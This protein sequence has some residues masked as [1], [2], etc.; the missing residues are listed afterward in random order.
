MERERGEG[1]RE[2]TED[3]VR[4]RGSQRGIRE[5]GVSERDRQTEKQ[6]EMERESWEGGRYKTEDGVRD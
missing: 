4:D 5:K 2:K 6:R 3:G 1:R